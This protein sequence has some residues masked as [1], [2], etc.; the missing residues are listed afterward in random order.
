MNLTQGDIKSQLIK[1]AFPAGIGMMF[2]T[3]YN[4]T[5]TF[6]AGLIGSEAIGAMAIT[7]PVFF[8]LLALAIGFS[9]GTTALISNYIGAKDLRS[10]CEIYIQALIYSLII[11]IAVG[12]MI[13]YSSEWIFNFFGADGNFLLMAIS[14]ISV[15][16]LGAPFMILNL[17]VNSALNSIGDT[18]KNRNIMIFGFFLNIGLNPILC[19]GLFLIPSLGIAGIALSTVIVQVIATIYLFYYVL[20]TEMLKNFDISMLKIKIHFLKSFISQSLPTCSSYLMIAFGFFVITKFVT[21]Y[22]PSAAAAFGIACRI[23]ELILL[24]TI[25]LNTALLSIVGQSYGAKKF[26]RVRDSYMISLKIGLIMMFFGFLGLIFFGEYLSSLFTKDLEVIRLSKDYLF[27]FAFSTFFFVVTHMSGSIF[28]GIKKPLY[29]TLYAFVRLGILPL[30]VLYT[31]DNYFD[32]GLNG[33]WI[34]ILSI[35]IVAAII[36]FYHLKKVLFSIEKI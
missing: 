32:F 4:I 5:D 1:I 24:P 36:I 28:Q 30:T 13:F 35:N 21:L 8:I 25:G 31:I 26:R 23:E 12:L 15:I 6:Y 14:Y 29:T 22:G 34:G 27:I 9:Q 3:F 7:F 16:A 2:H 18:K 10:A 17:V 11:S 19:F 33:I 20:K